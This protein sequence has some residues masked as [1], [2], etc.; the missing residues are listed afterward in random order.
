MRKERNKR[1]EEKRDELKAG[2]VQEKEGV[3][4]IK[5]DAKG[6]YEKKK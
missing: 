1:E 3:R 6:R 5:K 2:K 4:R